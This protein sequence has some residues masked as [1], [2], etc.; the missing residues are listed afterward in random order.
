ML[1]SVDD[2]LRLNRER[3]GTQ[4]WEA[5]SYPP[6]RGLTRAVE[7]L[8]KCALEYIACSMYIFALL[9]CRRLFAVV[10]TEWMHF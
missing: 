1:Q 8:V 9:R 5:E 3:L 10:L 2:H 4:H 7:S 6:K